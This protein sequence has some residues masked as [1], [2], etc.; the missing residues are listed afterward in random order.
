MHV[1]VRLRLYVRAR[2]CVRVCR[3]ARVRVSS[4]A[5]EFY[6]FLP[7]PSALCL[8]GDPSTAFEYA[9]HGQYGALARYVP[10]FIV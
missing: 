4:R 2:V 7:R 3:A 6:C 1:R 8:A 10:V 9:G 5:G